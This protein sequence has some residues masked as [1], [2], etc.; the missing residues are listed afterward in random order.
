[1]S[2]GPERTDNQGLLK[3]LMLTDPEITI[4]M[5]KIQKLVADL[6]DT[7]GGKQNCTESDRL[8]DIGGGGGGGH[9]QPQV[10]SIPSGPDFGGPGLP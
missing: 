1:M 3:N 7:T 8:R 2:P 9:V 10:A 5:L 6:P 4:I